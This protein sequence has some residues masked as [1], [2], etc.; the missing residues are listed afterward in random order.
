MSVILGMTS[1]QVKAVNEF[2]RDF[3]Q[4]FVGS[5]HLRSFSEKVNF[6]Q[7][8]P[9]NTAQTRQPQTFRNEDKEGLSCMP[10]A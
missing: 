6:R 9:S 7:W 4:N 1:T 2:G 8:A 3:L 10:I 5:E